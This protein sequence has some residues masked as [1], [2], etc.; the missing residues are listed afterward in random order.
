MGF[1][2][3]MSPQ[4]FDAYLNCG[5]LRHGCAR[6]HRE[7]CNHSELIAFSCK[8]RVLCPSCTAKR[9]HIFSETLNETIL[10]PHPHV[11]SL[12]LPGVITPSGEYQELPEIDTELLTELSQEKVLNA[13]LERDLLSEDDVNLMR[14]WSHS[15][16]NVWVGEDILTEEEEERLFVSRYLVLP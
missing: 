13:F 10:V 1:L 15:G 4:S 14:S 5:I 3:R 7:E 11:P 2:E 12:V 9:G 6:A 16:F 8:E